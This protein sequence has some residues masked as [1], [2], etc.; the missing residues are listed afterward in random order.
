M[1]TASKPRSE[2]VQPEITRLPE[3]SFWRRLLRKLL[4]A[5][6]KLMVLIFTRPV[7]RGLENVPSQ[8]ALIMV[9]NHLGDADALLG[10][11]YTPRSVD[12]LAKADLY[13][14]PVLGKLFDAYGVIWIRQGQP[15]RR[16]LRVALKGLQLGRA[17]GIAPE[18][19]ESLTGSLE[20]G[21]G[22]AAYIAYKSG[23]PILPVTMIG[24]ENWRIFGN[25]K[26]LRRTPVTLNIGQ[27]FYL[28]EQPDRRQAVQQGTEQIMR[29]LAH[30]L[31][32][33]YRGVF[34]GDEP[35]AAD[36]KPDTTL[37]EREPDDD[38]EH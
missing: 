10:L 20:E 8:G 3:L 36:L 29:A 19:R 25:M 32:P 21:T 38:R 2:V 1:P 34:Q 18:G 24:T 37:S 27:V 28:H 33:E 4:R 26:R 13:N 7:V 35:S 15:D 14:L 31:P 9:S 11:A 16:A 23:A 30:Q 12:L 22:G 17:I 5:V 6:L